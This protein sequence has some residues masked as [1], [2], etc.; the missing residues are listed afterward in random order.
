MPSRFRERRREGSSLN[1]TDEYFPEP[2]VRDDTWGVFGEQPVDWL[3]RSTLPRAASI[4]QALND[5]LGHFPERHSR[6][7]ARKLRTAWQSHYFEL[8][9]G[10]YLQAVS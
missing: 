9:V 1:R 5:N 10:R 8:I 3:M 4:R 2:S 7:L 6:S